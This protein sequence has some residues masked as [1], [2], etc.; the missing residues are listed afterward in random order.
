[1]L[2]P[3]TMPESVLLRI[4]WGMLALAAALYGYAAAS[5]LAAGR[6]SGGGRP[7]RRTI[8]RARTT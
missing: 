8:R 5:G 3:R 7:S 2:W 4:A 6:D 1:M